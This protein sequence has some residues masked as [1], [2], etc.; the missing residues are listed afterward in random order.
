[1][2]NTSWNTT[3]AFIKCIIETDNKFINNLDILNEGD[4]SGIGEGFAYKKLI[5]PTKVKKNQEKLQGTDSDLRKIKITDLVTIVTKLGAN[6][7]EAQ[8]LQR[9]DLVELFRNLV[10]KAKM[11]GQDVGAYEK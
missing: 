4:P 1:M 6:W 11:A 5:K 3:E 2:I 9:W 8:S 7:T 10:T